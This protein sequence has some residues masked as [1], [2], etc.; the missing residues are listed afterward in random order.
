LYTYPI[1][2]GEE[3]LNMVQKDSSSGEVKQNAERAARKVNP[4][5]GWVARA[6]YVS[7]GVVYATIGVLA[8][9]EALG[10]GGR[11]PGL[12]GAMYSIESQP[13][14]RIMLALLAFGLV[15]YALWKLTQGIMD[16]DD[17]GSGAHG[18]LRRVGYVG[19]GGVHGALAFM[20]AQAITGADDSSEDLMAASVMVYQPP[21]GQLVVGLASL[22]VIGVGIYQLYAAYGAKFRGELKRGEMSDANESLVTLAGRIGTAA[23]ALAIGIAGVFVLLAVYHSDPSETVGLGGALET[24]QDQPLG[25][26]M[27]GAV[28]V[29]LLIYGAFMLLVARYR[30]IKPT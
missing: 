24:L 15:G 14:G 4:W 1:K 9:Q 18:I 29:G 7:K 17:K 13:F 5:I 16:P 19:S 20:A 2:T 3:N 30:C 22:I 28:G 8:M 26:Y 10:V 25:S 12:K 23:R 6:G 27:L 21:F 11:A